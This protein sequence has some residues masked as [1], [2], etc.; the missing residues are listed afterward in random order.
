MIAA[1]VALLAAANLTSPFGPASATAEVEGA[2]IAVTVEVTID[3]GYQPD[4]VVVHLLNPEG[5][6]TFTLGPTPE[7]TY[8]GKF[9]VLPFNRALVFEVGREGDF[10]QSTTVSLVD[11]GIDP[12]LLQTTYRPPDSSGGETRWAWLALGA[13]ALAAATLLALFLLPGP[14]KK[15]PTPLVDTTGDE[16]VVIDDGNA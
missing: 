16:T 13:G 5:Q 11:L 12:D 7:G 2:Y 4:Y 15:S 8:S 3:P 1:V 14:A 10:V 9:T 6:E